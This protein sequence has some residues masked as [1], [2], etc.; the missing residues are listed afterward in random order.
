MQPWLACSSHW[1][2]CFVITG[3]ALWRLANESVLRTRLLYDCNPQSQVVTGSSLILPKEFLFPKGPGDTTGW[4]KYRGIF[5]WIISIIQGRSPSERS[6]LRDV[7]S[8]IWCQKCRDT[9]CP[10]SG[11]SLPSL[12]SQQR[13]PWL[14]WILKCSDYRSDQTTVS[15]VA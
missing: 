4:G 10:V 15:L 6:P 12:C 5:L 8:F 1:S 2:S 14:R 11:V 3:Y 7:F 13:L 9:F